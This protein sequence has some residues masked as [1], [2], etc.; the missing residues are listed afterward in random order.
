MVLAKNCRLDVVRK[1]VPLWAAVALA[2][3]AAALAAAP[4]EAIPGEPSVAATVT[5]NDATIDASGVNPVDT[6]FLVNFTGSSFLPQPHMLWVNV[7]F[8]TDTGW[9]VNP[10][11]ANLTMTVDSRTS[12]TKEVSVTV[13]VPPKVAANGAAIFSA[14]F[15]EQND[16]RFSQGQAGN[17]TAQIHIRQ[18][19][20]TGA[21]FE[22]GT[23]QLSVRQG[24]NANVSIRV[25]NRGNGDASYD[26]E[27]RNAGDL[28]PSDILLQG[29]TPA[30][31]VLN[32]TGIVRMVIHANQQAIIGTYQLQIRVAASGSGTP[33][34]SGAFADLTAQLVVLV[35]ATQPPPTN[36]TTQPPPPAHNNTTTIPPPPNNPDMIASLISGISS[37]PGM[38]GTGILV[39]ALLAVGLVWR[40]HTR[41]KRARLEALSKAR[42]RRQGPGAPQPGAPGAALARPSAP[43]P[44]GP[45]GTGLR[46]ASSV[47]PVRRL[48]VQ[49]RPPS[50]SSP[51]VPP[52]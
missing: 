37:P 23:T 38:I 30:T 40:R 14:A 20:S 32:G 5:P 31:V 51:S 41:A 42:Q 9:K 43:L 4:V 34:P 35:S 39:A 1:A 47:K 44:G 24:Q 19:F 22:N 52:K 27:L 49:S 6:S 28:R 25:S 17:A 33:P 12:V 36:N 10:S 13:T 45:A 15:L 18:I 8:S 2:G 46:P 3:F 50:P 48:A 26:A 21:E 29:T 11:F 16:I 7:S